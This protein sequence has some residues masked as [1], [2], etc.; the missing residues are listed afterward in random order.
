MI[1]SLFIKDF[2]LIDE[3]EINFDKSLNVL[4]GETGSG[5]SVII[6]AI[7]F[8]FGARASKDQ[9]KTG[10]DKALIELT[11]EFNKDL[12]TE[13]LEEN[14]IEFE[15]D[16]IL[17]ISREITQSTTRSRIN[18]SLVTQSFIQNLRKY[19]IDI[20]SQHETYNYLN[21]KCILVFFIILEKMT[22]K[23]F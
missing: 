3:Q 18:G 15:N 21:P 22:I 2:I 14:G 10:S 16:R 11:V 8:A 17:V 7:D 19:L 20:H 1:K 23:N 13:I 4:T 12:P 5:K 6:D 9:I